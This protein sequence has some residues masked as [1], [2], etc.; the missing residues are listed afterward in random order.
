MPEPSFTYIESSIY[1]GRNKIYTAKISKNKKYLYGQMCLQWLVSFLRDLKYLWKI[2]I[3]Y[4]TT[5]NFGKPIVLN[6][7]GEGLPIILLHGSSGNHLEWIESIAH[8]ETHFLDNPIYAFSI[9]MHLDEEHNH[10][11]YIN[12][13]TGEKIDGNKISGFKM[14]DISSEQDV[15][16]EQFNQKVRTYVKFVQKKH[17]NKKVI[18]IGH[19]MG[20]LLAHQYILKEGDSDIHSIVTIASPLNGSP[21]LLNRFILKSM[22]SARHHQMRPGSDYLIGLHNFIGNSI[23]Y[24]PTLSIGSIN[25]MHVPDEYSR[26][27][28]DVAGCLDNYQHHTLGGYGHFSIVSSEELWLLIK[29]FINKN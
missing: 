8:L 18:L 25:D 26:L 4:I 9:D 11:Y 20:G 16:I 21:L 23:N 27:P 12:P 6:K 28:W 15:P 22:N 3:C 29:K 17:N 19:S 13:H 5:R 10:Q 7:Y 14:K 2:M 1:L 24:P